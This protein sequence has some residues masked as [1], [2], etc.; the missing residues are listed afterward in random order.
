MLGALDRYM[1]SEV[2]WTHPEGGL[3]LW[4]H[5]PDVIDIQAL[6]DAAIRRNVAFVPGHAFYTIPNPPPTARLN[7]SCMNEDQIVEGIRRLSDA[8]HQILR[9]ANPIAAL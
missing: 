5:F 1:P 4:A 9:E 7:F 6:F 2:E 3:F 8:T